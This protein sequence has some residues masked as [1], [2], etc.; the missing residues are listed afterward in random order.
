[1]QMKSVVLIFFVS[2]FSMS[3]GSFKQQV[4]FNAPANQE[5]PESIEN[6]YSL[7]IFSD[8]ING[9]HWFTESSQ[10][11]VSIPFMNRKKSQKLGEKE[12]WTKKTKQCLS[13]T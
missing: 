1:M 2:V 6:F 4:L 9:E 13:I 8:N 7:D 3:C 5:M 12:N 11:E 10:S